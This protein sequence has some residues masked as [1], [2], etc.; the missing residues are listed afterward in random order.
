MGIKDKISEKFGV[1]KFGERIW[2]R[3]GSRMHTYYFPGLN[4]DTT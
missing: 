3:L 1:A 4:S 2:D